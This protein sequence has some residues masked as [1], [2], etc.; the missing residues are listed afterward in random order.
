MIWVITSNIQSVSD[1]NPELI[2]TSIETYIPMKDQIRYIFNIFSNKKDSE[3]ENSINNKF[4][5]H[6][7]NSSESSLNYQIRKLSEFMR[8]KIDGSHSDILDELTILIACDPS[9]NKTITKK[10]SEELKKI[11]KDKSEI[12][13]KDMYQFLKI[14]NKDRL[15]ETLKTMLNVK[16]I[17]VDDPIILGYCISEAL[18]R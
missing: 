2:L 5:Y 6:V 9:V 4:V 14:V 15:I 8:N 10:L 13:V 3:L 11:Q 1:P 16:Q 7:T 17:N 18:R 12:I